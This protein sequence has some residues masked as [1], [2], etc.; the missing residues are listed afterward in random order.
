MKPGKK[1]IRGQGQEKI[2]GMKKISALCAA[3]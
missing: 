1:E 3:V 2:I